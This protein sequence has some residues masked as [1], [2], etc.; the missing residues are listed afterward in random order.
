LGFRITGLATK[1]RDGTIKYKSSKLDYTTE[2]ILPQLEKF[3]TDY[4]EKLRVDYV[5]ELLKFTK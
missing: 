1:F 2:K 3:F 4:E 5:E